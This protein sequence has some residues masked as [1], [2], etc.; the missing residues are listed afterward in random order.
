MI[1]CEGGREVKEGGR[2]EGRRG[3]REGGE[4]ERW[5]RGGGREKRKGRLVN[6]H[7]KQ[8]PSGMY[9]EH[10]SNTHLCPAHTHTT[11]G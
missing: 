10:Y 3:E 6:L 1:P 11:R 8:I 4:E 5:R 2:R 7:T 9:K